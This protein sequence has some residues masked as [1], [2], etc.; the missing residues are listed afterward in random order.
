MEQ[1][2]SQQTAAI[3]QHHLECFSQGDLDALMSDYA[4]DAVLIA[5]QGLMR[6]SAQ[7]R[8]VFKQLMEDMPPGSQVELKCQEIDDDT[9]FLLWSGESDRVSIPMGT[10][11]FMIQ[12]GKI[13][14]QTF[15]AQVNRKSA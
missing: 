11:T 5:P 6:G 4:D 15:A 1:T 14:K 10:D 3:L 13:H 12:D 2:L 9:A 7:I 8:G